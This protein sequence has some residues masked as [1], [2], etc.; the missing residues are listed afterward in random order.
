M[1]RQSAIGRVRFDADW[2][3]TDIYEFQVS[4]PFFIMASAR[5][6]RNILEG[7]LSLNGK[8]RP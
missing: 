7:G 8:K 3:L 2:I 4:V 1:L 5:I 6:V